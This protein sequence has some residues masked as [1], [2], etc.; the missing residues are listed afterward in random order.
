MCW[1]LKEQQLR[2]PAKK[3]EE[4]RVTRLQ[5]WQEKTW[6]KEKLKF[7]LISQLRG[8]KNDTWE[9]YNIRAFAVFDK[10]V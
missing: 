6:R 9:F 7:I 10:F 1:F 4:Y 2:S 8:W 5:G 3:L